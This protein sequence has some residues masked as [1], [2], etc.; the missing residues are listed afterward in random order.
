MA[1]N[2]RT[3]TD[4]QFATISANVIHQ[5]LIEVSRTVGKR[6]FR[7]LEAGTRIALTQLQMEDGGQVRLD[8]KL[9]HSEF[10]G[11]LNFSLFRDSVLA[12]LSRLSDNLRD[13][14]ASLPVMRMMDE[15][16]QA[17]SERRLFGVPGVIVVDGVPNMLLMGATPSASEPVVLIELMYIDPE[18]FVQSDASEASSNS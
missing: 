15:S 7:E 2:E 5:S 8:A 3:L 17:T 9:D 10:R 11:A 14:E 6:I 16:G 12:M 4:E 13:E 18:Q 1:A